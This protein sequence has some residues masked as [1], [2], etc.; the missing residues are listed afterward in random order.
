MQADKLLVALSEATEARRGRVSEPWLGDPPL[1]HNGLKQII[2]DAL[3][4]IEGEA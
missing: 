1:T 4:Q 2:E 3:D